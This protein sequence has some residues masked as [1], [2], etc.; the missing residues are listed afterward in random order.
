MTNYIM[1]PVQ[2]DALW[3]PQP[4]L[5]VVSQ[6]ADFS[7]LPF[8][9]DSLGQAFNPGVA[10][11][12]ESIAAH[13]FH[14]K[15]HHLDPGVHLH[16]ALPDALTRG[17]SSLNFPEVPNRWLITRSK[18][19]EK[20]KQWVVESD[21]LWPP[22]INRKGKN[23]SVPHH[24]LNWLYQGK[25]G[26][27]SL[28]T[29]WHYRPGAYRYNKSDLAVLNKLFPG[30]FKI[31]G[32]KLLELVD[33]KVLNDLFGNIDSAHELHPELDEVTL[34]HLKQILLR[35]LDRSRQPYRYIGRVKQDKL[36]QHH[37]D[38]AEYF[39]ELTAIGYG[40]PEFAALYSNCFS[41]FGFHDPQPG[42]DLSEVSY[43]VAGWYDNDKRD[44]VQKG[45]TKLETEGKG[46]SEIKTYLDDKYHWH[47]ADQDPEP[48]RLLCYG[49]IQFEKSPTITKFD[50]KVNV[51]VAN[52]SSEAL[53]VCLAQKL[54]NQPQLQSLIEDQLEAL[55][56]SYHLD[57]KGLDVLALFQQLRH[58]IGFTPVSGGYLW[59]IGKDTNKN[60]EERP[61][62]GALPDSVSELL[63]EINQLQQQYDIAIREIDALR[64]QVFSDWHK[65][66]TCVYPADISLS[67]YPPIDQVKAF[68][69]CHSLNLLKEKV[70]STGTIIIKNEKEKEKNNGIIC[71]Y[72]TENS[73]NY[74]LAV[75]L[76]DAINQLNQTLT[77]E[78][79]HHFLKQIPAPR[80]W[81]AND[82]VILI[83][84]NA[85]KATKRHGADGELTCTV[86]SLDDKKPAT[87]FLSQVYEKINLKLEQGQ[88]ATYKGRPWNP[89]ALEWNVEFFPVKSHS[90]HADRFKKYDPDYITS[91]YELKDQHFDLSLEA[92]K[93]GLTRAANLY[94]GR[95]I[96]TD[97]VAGN[98]SKLINRKENDDSAD[99]ANY[100]QPGYTFSKVK[101][102][103]PPSKDPKDSINVLAQSLTGFNRALLMQEQ[104]L[105]LPIEDPMAFE[106]Y[107]LFTNDIIHN[108]VAGANRYAPTPQT[109][110]NPVRAGCLK[111]LQ[112][113]LI[114]T[115]GQT[116]T[117]DV[118]RVN[119]SNKMAVPSHPY[120]INLPPRITQPAKLDFRW[121]SAGHAYQESHSQQ[122]S[123]PI[124]G[125]LLTNKFDHSLMFFN[126]T[127]E[128]L[129]FFKAG[130]WHKAIGSELAQGLTSVDE[131]ANP[132]LQ[133]VAQFVQ[134]NLNHNNQNNQNEPFLNQFIH[135]LDDALE[136]MHPESRGSVTAT[137]LLIG[138]PLAVV[139]CSLNLSL[140]GLPAV[141]QGWGAFKDDMTSTQRCTDNFGA[142]KWPIRLGEHS[143]FGD[144]LAGYWL[145]DIDSEGV[146][147]FSSD[148]SQL[149]R[150]NAVF[151]TPQTDERKS[152][153]IISLSSGPV[154]VYQSV[155]DKPQLASMLV[156]VQGE[157]HA[158][159]GFLPTK[160]INIPS[161]FYKNTLKNIE[162]TFLHAPLLTPEKQLTLPLRSD[163]G[164]SWTWLQCEQ[165][166]NGDKQQTRWLEIS[167]LKS[168]DK[169]VFID[170]YENLTSCRDGVHLW[171]YLSS[172]AVYWLDP[173][174]TDPNKALV[175]AKDKRKLVTTG[176]SGKEFSSEYKGQEEKV[177]K[178]LIQY[179]QGIDSVSEFAQFS[180]Q[181]LIKEGWLKLK[182]LE[183]N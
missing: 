128:A 43:D 112:L 119:T 38:Q 157:V 80:Y 21:Y 77:S 31:V 116:R 68:I 98:L 39:S 130:K 94:T 133:R 113:R 63:S 58:Q 62:E 8:Y 65:Y 82:P 145:E 160:T 92:N 114:D 28:Q 19:G 3:V 117:L 158:T 66:M 12:A 22:H 93:G 2:V 148:H 29:S 35:P 57:E 36:W 135:T 85:A 106:D 14:N 105:Q 168:I 139:R 9:E 86:V 25:Q 44:L 89:F 73:A 178:I 75:R 17:D 127:G 41:V 156:D 53:S 91:N 32:D 182:L 165:S 45:L 175:V 159:C 140:H 6:K 122:S 171:E 37:D 137:S 167:E 48:D 154:N 7:Q 131:I 5:S 52:T 71:V 84:G 103:L 162:T 109:G 179:A 78:K 104:T 170:K 118:T 99:L 90:N 83:E 69:E 161:D 150:D 60:G 55:Q 79:T 88:R 173:Q 181:Q 13:P 126:Q 26:D 101:A 163:R 61:E 16:W 124:C 33:E 51:A 81:Q 100:E 10:N 141:N 18:A 24:S 166:L 46:R 144:G 176:L 149:S 121:L 111:I 95:S 136:N 70:K 155:E 134:D 20:D 110:F 64:S 4:G 40:D 50:D 125:W 30:A 74:S 153:N 15:N 11:L 102:I 96:L 42:E 27:D 47:L 129:G 107:R 147:Q 72:V 56:L 67:H 180:G 1:V 23:V 151:Y 177:E 164:Q 152:A 54:S 76:M 143:Q 132:Y 97:H 108:S 34:A 138:R 174:H 87:D 146:V 183:K 169:N 172:K 49:G 120:L 123:N 142:V 115:F 59:H